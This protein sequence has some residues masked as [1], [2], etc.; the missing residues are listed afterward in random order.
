MPTLLA[1]QQTSRTGWRAATPFIYRTYT[2]R[3]LDDHYRH[4]D[5]V[6]SDEHPQKERSR[7]AF[8]YVK[9]IDFQRWP[10]LDL[11]ERRLE[12]QKQRGKDQVED[13]LL[14]R[15]I[16]VLNKALE[17]LRPLKHDAAEVVEEEEDKPYK[18]E[19]ILETTPKTETPAEQLLFPN[20]KHFK[21]GKE[22]LRYLGETEHDI[23]AG[24]E[25][26]IAP[27]SPADDH[28]GQA[29]LAKTLDRISTHLP[30]MLLPLN[31]ASFAPS[32]TNVEHL[33]LD[34]ALPGTEAMDTDSRQRE[35]SRRNRA[36]TLLRIAFRLGKTCQTVLNGIRHDHDMEF[37]HGFCDRLAAWGW[38]GCPCG[39]NSD[40]YPE[41]NPQVVID[42]IT[43]HLKQYAE[44]PRNR[45]LLPSIDGEIRDIFDT[46]RL[47][48]CATTCAAHEARMLAEQ[49]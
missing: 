44:R 8:N 17:K 11:F 45:W 7:V 37:H 4:S 35:Q 20:L 12:R 15:E 25:Q 34:Y 19:E 21:I 14:K 16:R 18:V 1:I 26:T 22:A 39:C 6:F 47:E 46:K 27:Y 13:L 2:F 36:A 33:C 43:R 9:K 31:M 24:E 32:M 10:P 48:I 28:N 5:W 3:N 41:N 29:R 30:R 49:G 23:T 40:I 38:L 42:M